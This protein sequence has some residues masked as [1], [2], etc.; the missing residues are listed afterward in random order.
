MPDAAPHDIPNPQGQLPWSS[1]F[2][3][4]LRLSAPI[5]PAMLSQMLIG[6]FDTWMVSRIGCT[7]FRLGGLRIPLDTVSNPDLG[8]ITLSAITP[9]VF[10]FIAVA[11]L[12]RGTAFGVNSFASQ[13]LGKG[14]HAEAGRYAWQAIYLAGLS[15]LAS[16]GVYAVAGRLPTRYAASPEVYASALAYFRVMVW[17][18][19]AVVIMSGLQGFFQGVHRPSLPAV[20]GVASNVV[21]V[22]LNWAMIYG[23]AGLPRMGM[24]GAALASVIANFLA[25]AALLAC[26][27]MPAFAGPYRTRRNWRPSL[28][29]FWRLIW[30]GAPMGASWLLDLIGW[31]VM[32]MYITQRVGAELGNAHPAASNAAMT[33]LQLGFMPVVGVGL[34]VS[35]LV[36]RA[37]G[38]RQFAHA[39]R[40]TAAGFILGGG[41]QL[42]IGVLLVVF[43]R[44][45]IQFFNDDP[46]VVRIGSQALIWAGAFQFFDAM[47]IIYASALRGAGDTHVILWTSLVLIGGL[48]VPLS[49]A[50]TWWVMPRVAPSLLSI[51]PWIAGTIYIVLLGVGFWLRWRSSAWERVDIFGRQPAAD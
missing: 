38:A 23:R 37:M 14:T 47:G 17:S 42:L 18:L 24:A 6:F 7:E 30:I 50:I 3:Q 51:G 27:F 12:F 48:F 29:R 36:G 39:R 49:F 32:I 28:Y 11:T 8:T 20:I 40:F 45:L 21:N 44:E 31:S 10:A 41:Y 1:G 16:A 35:A 22:L 2:T 4:V 15:L 19:P 26:F 25:A 34:G 9:A 33:Y 46:E 5:I 43:R 13:S